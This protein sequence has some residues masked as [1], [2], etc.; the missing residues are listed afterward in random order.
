MAIAGKSVSQLLIMLIL[1]AIGFILARRKLLDDRGTQQISK[2]LTNLV[3]PASIVSSL[4][5]PY[6]PGIVHDILWSVFIA[7]LTIAVSILAGYFVLPKGRPIDMYALVFTNTGFIALPLIQNVIGNTGVIFLA[8]YMLTAAFAQLTYGR[9]LLSGNPNGVRWKEFAASP[10]V[11]GPVVGLA[12][13]FGRITLPS[14]I[15]EPVRFLAQA[16]TLLAMI[17]LGS[18]I[19]QSTLTR[20]FRDRRAYWIAFFGLILLPLLCLMAIRLLPV[21]NRTLEMS[22]LI[23]VSCPAAANLA[24]LGRDFGG[25]YEYGRRLV[26]VTTLLSFVT[27]PFLVLIGGLAF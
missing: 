21:G 26:I 22:L 9:V 25:D 8:V 16:N 18:Y 24:L 13:Y 27:I 11:I 15:G 14:L 23:A 3:I 7:A 5:Q 10:A 6:Q 19:G 1:M 4:Q 12:L 17:V 20:V 2:I